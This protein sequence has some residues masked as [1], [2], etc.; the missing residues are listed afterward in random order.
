MGFHIAIAYAKAN[1]SGLVISSRTTSDLDA[2]SAEIRKVN[3]NVEILAQ[4]CD[5]MK[6]DDVEKLVEAT[7]KR[8][9]RL[10]VCIANAG[11]ISKYLP[12]GLVVISFE[13]R[14]P[15]S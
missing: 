12:D 14:V 8:F 2:L 10:D 4:V 3:L 7:K 15:I 1:V 9:G 13:Q 11:V 5:T 6:D